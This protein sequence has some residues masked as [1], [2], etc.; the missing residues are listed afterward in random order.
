MMSRQA[1]ANIDA[2]IKVLHSGFKTAANDPAP[3]PSPEERNQ[4]RC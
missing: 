2:L 4:Y 1:I 3:G